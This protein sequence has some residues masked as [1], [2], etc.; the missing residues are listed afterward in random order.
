MPQRCWACLAH[1]KWDMLEGGVHR[2]GE[3]ENKDSGVTV[4]KTD[5]G[6]KVKR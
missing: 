2:R 5:E 4:V 6:E 3:K 1:Q